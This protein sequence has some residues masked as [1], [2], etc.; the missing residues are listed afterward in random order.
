MDIDPDADVG[1]VPTGHTNTKA[2]F[3][4]LQNIHQLTCDE[5]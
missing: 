5:F 2:D 1:G 3:D 4:A